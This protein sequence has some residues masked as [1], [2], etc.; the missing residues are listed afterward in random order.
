M[1]TSK[2][3]IDYH[4]IITIEPGKRSGKPCIR[5]LRITV[6]DIL[7]CFAAGMTEEEVLDDYDYLTRDDIRACFAYASDRERHTRVIK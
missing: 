6:D 1:E 4:D 2:M 5:G 7:D 3:S